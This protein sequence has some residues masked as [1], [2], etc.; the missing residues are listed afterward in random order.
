MVFIY[1]VVT[2]INLC[3]VLLKPVMLQMA[4]AEIMASQVLPDQLV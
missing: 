1:L 2:I 3:V 4:E